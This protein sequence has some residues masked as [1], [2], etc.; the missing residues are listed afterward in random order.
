MATKRAI[1]WIITFQ[2]S[3]DYYSLQA[4]F[5][6]AGRNDTV[7]RKEYLFY[8]C[9]IHLNQKLRLFV[10]ADFRRSSVQAYQA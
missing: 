7:K 8:K 1:R 4:L 3:K 10:Q 2:Q 9:D 5:D 6:K